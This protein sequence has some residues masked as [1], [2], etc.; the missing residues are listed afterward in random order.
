MIVKC[1]YCGNPV[2]KRDCYRDWQGRALCDYCKNELRIEDEFKA[3]L[4]RK[5]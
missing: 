3:A 5:S 4:K 1:A 2:D